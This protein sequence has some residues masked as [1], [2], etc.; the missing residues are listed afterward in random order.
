MKPT[1]LL[2]L[3]SMALA[4]PGLSAASYTVKPG[5]GLAKIARK[6]GCTPAALAKANGL[7]LSSVIHPGQQLKLPESAA[8]QPKATKSSAPA[9][10]AGK[11]HTIRPGD[12][13]SKIARQYGISV[14]SL[15]TANPDT[16]AT[17]LR[18][19]QTIRLTAA[20]PA[21][22]PAP[23]VT[24]PAEIASASKPAPAPAPAI[25]PAPE[26]P[27]TAAATPSPPTQPAD[28]AQ[29]AENPPEN[30][31][32][33][34]SSSPTPEKKIRSII[35]EDE[36]TYAEFAAKHGTNISRLNDLNGLDLTNATVLAKGS[37]LYVP[38]Q[39]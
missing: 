20:S 18:P 13:Y 19:G 7:K 29:V 26:A 24:P 22:N 16:K 27:A 33:A 31:P 9:D 6:T 4:S 36:M 10:L 3:L 12:T 1:L 2:T 11:T 23:A 17:A 30:S 28:P 25:N 39:P 8:S 14:Q 35:I 34:A 5:D 38:A 21:T 37:E 15:V 32:P